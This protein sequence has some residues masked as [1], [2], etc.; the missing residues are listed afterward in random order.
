M[1]HLEDV[2][3]LTNLDIV[4]LRRFV[5]FSPGVSTKKCIIC[6]F[7]LGI[8]VFHLLSKAGQ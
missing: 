8:V 7:E 6:T 1:L 5:P 3:E 2:N 4:S